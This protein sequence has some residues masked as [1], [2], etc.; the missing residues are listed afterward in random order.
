MSGTAGA[1]VGRGAVTISQGFTIEEEQRFKVLLKVAAESPFE[2]ERANALA[3][4]TRLAE[5]NGLTLDEAAAGHI[6][7]P[8]P[9]PDP[10]EPEWESQGGTWWR[11]PKVAS[12]VHLLDE[13]IR[14]DKARR[15]EAL[16][17]A[18]A[19]GL[20]AELRKPRRKAELKAPR[21]GR[22]R[23]PYS[24]ARVLLS[25]TSLPLGE[26]S[27]ITGLDPHEVLALALKMRGAA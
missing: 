22:R 27:D 16:Q 17:A 7:P 14:R 23:E 11:D 8:R 21:R 15:D 1:R 2:G 25:E 13:Q 24:H 10:G 3:A 19:R 6:E 9:D 12:Y 26:I 18:Y 4:A 20:D 5:R